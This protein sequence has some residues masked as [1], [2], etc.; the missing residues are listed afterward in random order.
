[1]NYTEHLFLVGGIALLSFFLVSYLFQRLKI[2]SL[3]AYVFLGLA[4]SSLLTGPELEIVDGIAR[5]GI[6]LLFFL[7][8]LHFPLARLINISRRVW[9]VGVMDIGLNFGVSFGLAYLLGFDLL[10]AL[11]IGGVAYATSSS[12]TVKL[13]EDSKRLKTPEGE[14]KLALLVFEDLPAP[15]MVSLLA[16]LL[17]LGEVTAAAVGMIFVKVV[18]LTAVSILVAVHGFRRLDLFAGRYM[19][20][21]FMPLFA[22]AV[23][24][25][26]AG[27]AEALDLSKLLG[28]FLAGMM[29]S[30]TGTSKEFSKIIAPVKDITLPFFFFW[31]GTTITLGAGMVSVTALAVLL[32]WALAGKLIV[33]FWG[34]RMYGLSFK[35]SIR[36][37]FS[38]MQRGEFSVVIAALAEPILRAF[39]GIYIVITAIA[40]VYLFRWAPRI[41]DRLASRAGRQDP[42]GH[43]LH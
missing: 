20:K 10:A 31:F 11:I 38:L 32:F 2:P 42:R 6:L 27:I 9:S 14:F 12:I 30:E 18:V 39:L 1:M 25:I 41:A 23:G 7:L 33:G 21:D 4:L 24:L 5:L 16:G 8:G 29:L 40:G 28:A 35:G 37:A 17:L 19:S 34:G 15:V 26:F 22:F 36:A 3:L 43:G 13:L